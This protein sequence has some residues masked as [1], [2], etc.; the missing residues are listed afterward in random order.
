MAD[1]EVKAVKTYNDLRQ[2]KVIGPK[3]NS[4][5]VS[6]ERADHLVNQGMVEIV[7]T[8]TAKAKEA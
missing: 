7:K 6:K 3:D 5:R 8:V 2:N 1:A 4:F